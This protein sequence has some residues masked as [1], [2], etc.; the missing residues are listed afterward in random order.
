MCLL[1]LSAL[2]RIEDGLREMIRRK[3][4]PGRAHNNKPRLSDNNDR[5]VHR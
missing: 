4:L 1:V 2:K 5:N 3:N